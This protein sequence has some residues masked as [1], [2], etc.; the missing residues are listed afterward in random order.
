MNDGIR[1]DCYSGMIL[2]DGMRLLACIFVAAF[3]ISVHQF[4]Y[5][6]FR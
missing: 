3:M 6:D 5:S 2:N 1:V 4:A